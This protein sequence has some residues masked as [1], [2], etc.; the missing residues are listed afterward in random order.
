MP[1]RRTESNYYPVIVVRAMFLRSARCGAGPGAL[2]SLKLV[3]KNKTKNKYRTP[4][5]P[6]NLL[7]MIKRPEEV[8]LPQTWGSTPVQPKVGT[9]RF[10]VS[11]DSNLSMHSLLSAAEPS[12]A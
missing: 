9:G 10:L 12:S 6:F 8:E 2:L 3:I 11:K 4:R 5:I 1:L 7:M